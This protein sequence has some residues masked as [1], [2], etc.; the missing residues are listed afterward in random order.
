MTIMHQVQRTSGH[1]RRTGTP[2]LAFCKP[3]LPQLQINLSGFLSHFVLSLSLSLSLS[4]LYIYIYIYIY[5]FLPRLEVYCLFFSHFSAFSSENRFRPRILI[6]VS[7]ID[8]S[9]TVLGFKISMPI[10]I[11]PT[12]MQKMAHPEGICPLYMEL[13][14]LFATLDNSL[15]GSRFHYSVALLPSSGFGRNHKT[16]TNERP[17]FDPFT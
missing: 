6:D 7:K 3:C 15:D 16:N 11:A 10:M 4:I 13:E 9:T 17:D 8:M 14:D 1:L 2:S 12:A 5:V